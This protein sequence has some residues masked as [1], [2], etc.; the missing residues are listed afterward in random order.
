[1][2]KI[3]LSVEEAAEVLGVG[4]STVY[5]LVRMR[6]LR[7]VKIGSRR[8]IPVDACRELVDRLLEEEAV[9]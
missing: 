9:A 3:L 8:R 2:E 1:M 7:S 5:D 6:L 4:K